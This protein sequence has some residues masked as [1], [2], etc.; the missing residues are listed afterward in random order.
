MKK[1][2]S[3]RDFLRIASL[4]A[5]GVLVRCGTPEVVE[6]VVE[7]TV[8]VEKTVEVEVEK[9]V[10]VEKVVT[11]MPP[12]KEPVTIGF[13]N[14]WG[15]SREPLMDE[16][17]VRFQE[18]FPWITV[19]NQVQGW[20]NRAEIVAT[21]M[22]SSTPPPLI[23]L[24]SFEIQRF[25][26]DDLLLP[27]DSFAEAHGIDPYET[28]YAAEVDARKW[29]GELY[30]YPLPTAGGWSGFVIYNKNMMRD[31]GLDPESPPETWQDLEDLT[32]EVTEL[33]EGI[34]TKIGFQIKSH[35]PHDWDLRMQAYMNNGKYITDDRRELL[36]NSDEFVS[37]L[38]WMVNFTDQYYGG[39]QNWLTFTEVGWTRQ[40]ADYR[41]Y[42]EEMAVWR[43]GVF[44]FNQIKSYDPEMWEDTEQWGVALAPYNG[45]NPDAKTQGTPGNA[46]GQCIPTA[47]SGNVAE[48][49]YEFM[50]FFTARRAGGCWFLLEQGRPTPVK[51]CME[52]P[53]YY[54]A[55]PY[56]DTVR[57]AMATE[58]NVPTTPVTPEIQ[59]AVDEVLEQ[60]WFGELEPKEGLD[61][62]ADRGQAILDEFW[63]DYA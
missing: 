9:T 63:A 42:N 57:E 36:I 54:E 33:A 21:A 20:D 4:A 25:A 12:E 31:A 55:N 32:A 51:A 46:F 27:I 56:W 23:M 19:E 38:E 35:W 11:A 37:T 16:V 44:D 10:E 49:A 15:G 40:A 34:P 53:E 50:E 41:F 3:R 48:A 26:L 60:V 2:W 22:A 61:L 1:H 58:V 39:F 18:E 30:S 62:A 43:A 47:V 45:N 24:Q 14:W 6:K 17:I 52:N 5:G 29:E 7:R 8:E 13:M 28:F 59:A